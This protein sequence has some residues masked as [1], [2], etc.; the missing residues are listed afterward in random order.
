MKQRLY[1]PK[2]LAL[3]KVVQCIGYVEMTESDKP[4]GWFGILP[5]A[6]SNMT[7]S[8]DDTGAISYHDG[9]GPGLFYTCWNAPVALKKDRN[10]RFINV[11]LKPYG[12]Y[13]LRGCPVHE[14][15]NTSMDLDLFFSKSESEEL[16]DR[17]FEAT[18]LLEKFRQV[19]RFLAR[20]VNIELFEE[21]ISSAV[22]LLK[23]EN[24]TD[25]NSISDT[26][27]LSPRRFRELFSERVGLSPAF[28]KKIMR[29]HRACRQIQDGKISSLTDVA[30]ANNYYDQSHFIKDFKFFGGITP[31][32]FLKAKTKSADFYNYD[33]NDL[34]KF[35]ART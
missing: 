28:Y 25:L 15:Q 26:I 34:V 19:E 9:S 3:Q 29:F 31:S 10:L 1:F 14:L 21:R 18:T 24:S 12:L 16:F 17:V 6:S 22:F 5:N 8:L 27:C 4:D 32:Q 11:Q 20:H 23:K 35:E 33:M 13:Y 7:L 2:D 30:Y